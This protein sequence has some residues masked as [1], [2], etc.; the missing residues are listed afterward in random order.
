MCLTDHPW[1]L[2]VTLVPQ[3]LIL[4]IL[5]FVHP[6][7]MEDKHQGLE[8]S[9]TQ[10]SA[11]PCLETGPKMTSEVTCELVF[12]KGSG[13][14]FCLIWWENIFIIL[15]VFST[16]SLLEEVALVKRSSRTSLEWRTK[17]WQ[18]DCKHSPNFPFLYPLPLP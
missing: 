18:F 3:S 12:L 1:G 2:L 6:Y 7:L 4:K 15:A 5:C 10:V 17:S 16:I 14:I 13:V 11:L 9:G 8:K